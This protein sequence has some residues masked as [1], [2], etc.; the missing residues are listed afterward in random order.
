MN[1]M[2]KIHLRWHQ[3]L[4]VPIACC[5]L[6]L[7][8]VGC[9][10]DRGNEEELS[11]TYTSFRLRNINVTGDGET[12][13]KSIRLVM[14][15]SATGE[16]VYNEL[17]T[18]NNG[19]QV[20][21]ANLSGSQH[22]DPIELR[23][24]RGNYDFYLFAN[25]ES[26]GTENLSILRGAIGN[27]TNLSKLKQVA[28][29]SSEISTIDE[30]NKP[31]VSI[32]ILKSHTLLGNGTKENPEI[33][34]AALV[35]NVAKFTLE[36]R[37]KKA[38]PD[39]EALP[40]VKITGFELLNIPN[41]YNLL[42][43]SEPFLKE[44]S[45]SDLLDL[46]RQTVS[47]SD[48]DYNNTN[49]SQSIYTSPN[50]YFTEHLF[51]RGGSINRP[52]TLKVYFTTA[53]SNYTTEVSTTFPI[54]AHSFREIREGVLKYVDALHANLNDISGYSV[55]R[56]LHYKVVL[57][58]TDQKAEPTLDIVL[59]PWLQSE[60]VVEI[61]D[62]I[63]NATKDEVM[64]N[65]YSG[66]QNN[67]MILN[68]F[69]SG[70]LRWSIA[71]P[72]TDEWLQITSPSG[73]NIET[74][75][76]KPLTFKFTAKSFNDT[77]Y[78]EQGRPTDSERKATI[79]F[80]SNN[81]VNPVTV[82]VKQRPRQLI[83]PERR[84]VNFI[85]EGGEILIPVESF[86]REW[87]ATIVSNVSTI[88]IPTKWITATREG[89]AVR[90][91]VEST[92]DIDLLRHAEV[93]LYDGTGEAG[94]IWV[95]QGNYIPVTITESGLNYT[96]LDRNLGALNSAYDRDT[97]KI[98]SEISN[99]ERVSRNGYY[100]QQGRIPDGYHTLGIDHIKGYIEQSL[101][102]TSYNKVEITNRP[103]G[104]LKWGDLGTGY[105]YGKYT[106]DQAFGRFIVAESTPNYATSAEADNS[107]FT[108]EG[109][110]TPYP[111]WTT[112][113]GKKNKGVDPCPEGYRVPTLN[114]L[115]DILKHSSQDPYSRV[116]ESAGIWLNGQNFSGYDTDIYLPIV[117]KRSEAGFLNIDD[118]LY[119]SG[120]DEMVGCYASS[121]TDENSM[122][123][124]TLIMRSRGVSINNTY[125][126]G[127]AAGVA[128][129][130]IKETE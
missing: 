48:A 38:S 47:I 8:L 53:E 1:R 7:I 118:W 90:I 22:S 79:T 82:V 69:V 92:N 3:V 6:L 20:P 32:G 65:Y 5:L 103:N 107:W 51:E 33:V 72:N 119:D 94:Y 60:Q 50:Y 129:R 46:G 106:R 57:N 70:D 49:P 40:G 87:N 114:E 113:D 86:G 52:T 95:E 25:E 100:Y 58:I 30:T 88:F 13:I 97:W 112:P 36:V 54:D 34:S 74:L 128:V 9:K 11:N 110:N 121:T 4:E 2:D 71:E 75:D 124:V 93:K 68:N 85:N 111:S 83:R 108:K 64:L 120:A 63:F 56:G 23:T 62:Q 16:V 104:P 115:T 125:K 91:K 14:A 126:V 84:Y 27:T 101:K 45:E 81:Y 37:R 99:R 42:F 105:V 80:T 127:H 76:G 44:N 43:S 10:K 31:L 67:V 12:V 29:A 122:S 96:I 55:F 28:F 61:K 39:S 89:N 73:N 59:Q 77:S 116:D 130:C 109:S 98:G 15:K 26:M 102:N 21:P 19:N 17:L 41:K 78:D 117:P 35:R 24:G 66:A 18:W 123:V